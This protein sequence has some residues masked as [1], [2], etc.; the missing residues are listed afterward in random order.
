MDNQKIC[1]DQRCHNEYKDKLKAES[2]QIYGVEKCYASHKP[3]KGLIASH[4]KPY[5]LCV[6]EHD[7]DSEY[8]INN[9]LLLCKS[10]DDYF[11]KFLI[12][13]D[14]DGKIICSDS[15]PNE[16]QDEFAQY[17]LDSIIYN[18]ERKKYM[19]IHRSLFYYK[20][21]Y[22]RNDSVPTPLKLENIEIPYFDCGIKYF[23]DTFIILKNYYWEICPTFSLKQEFVKRTDYQFKYYI[24][25]ADFTSVLLKNKDY[26]IDTDNI[27]PYF[28]TP[29]KTINI[30]APTDN[31]IENKFKISL[32]NFDLNSDEPVQFIN[33]LIEMF[34][35]NLA[36]QSFR[37]IIN[38]ALQGKGYTHGIIL[39][40]D[41]KSS[42]LILSFIEKIIGSYFYEYP[43]TKVLYK[44]KA[45][46]EIPNCCIL[47]FR[48]HKSEV[49]QYNWDRIIKNDFFNSTILNINKYIPF[50][51]YNSFKPVK[52]DNTIFFRCKTLLNEYDLNKILELEGGAILNWFIKCTNSFESELSDYVE[53]TRTITADSSINEWLYC[54]CEYGSNIDAESK[55]VQ[56]YENYIEYAKANYISPVSS[57]YLFLRLSKIFQKKRY[58]FG[59]VY[60]G[61]KI[62]EK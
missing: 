15:V 39:Y 61:I 10:I 37:K 30:E 27:T 17:Q 21:F 18:D 45:L 9:G 8:S 20:N 24:S 49:S 60:I 7:T 42:D 1:R 13:F 4:I 29:S 38:Y 46:K 12:T 62:K 22:E 23:K 5:K 52:A 25:N 48:N 40:G 3:Y 31:T 32:S 53:E 43:D 19:Q 26:T 36:V 41:I 47:F 50:V 51:S 35:N 44:Q 2:R 54:N 33:I 14:N 11:D 34:E 55:A 6:L 28:N 16:I 58:S 59:M 56:L 57:R